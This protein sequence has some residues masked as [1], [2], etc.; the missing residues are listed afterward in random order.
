MLFCVCTFAPS[1][2]PKVLVLGFGFGFDFDF[3]LIV[4]RAS[5][6]RL[7]P[8]SVCLNMSLRMRFNSTWIIT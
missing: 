4:L 1:Y 3:E 2:L 8:Y 6:A 7:A 5:V